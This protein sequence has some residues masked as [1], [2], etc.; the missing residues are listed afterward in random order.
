MERLIGDKPGLAAMSARAKVVF[1]RLFLAESVHK[2]M[3]E[4]LSEVVSHTRASL[5]A[6]QSS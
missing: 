1:E 3:A 2:R 4:F 6:A 5:G